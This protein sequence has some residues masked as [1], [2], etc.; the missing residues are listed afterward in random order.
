MGIRFWRFVMK[1]WLIKLLI[2]VAVV[3]GMTCLAFYGYKNFSPYER[4][5]VDKDDYTLDIGHATYPSCKRRS[6]EDEIQL[7][8][9]LR[10]EIRLG[11]KKATHW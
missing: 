2:I 4:C 8:L 5:V 3:A 11:C 10:S 1:I 9:C 7:Q 6:G